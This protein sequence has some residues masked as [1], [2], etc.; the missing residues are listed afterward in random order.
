MEER[1]ERVLVEL[2]LTLLSQSSLA[3]LWLR[4]DSYASCNTATRLL[5]S[6]FVL[7]SQRQGKQ[8]GLRS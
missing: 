4:I 3:D 5:D 6:N 8:Y 1:L 2:L 7:A